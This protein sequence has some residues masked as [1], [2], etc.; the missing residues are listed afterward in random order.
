V[1]E[2]KVFRLDFDLIWYMRLQGHNSDHPIEMTLVARILPT[3]SLPTPAREAS[4]Q[5]PNSSCS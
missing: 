2:L 3:L 1:G 5:I 4:A